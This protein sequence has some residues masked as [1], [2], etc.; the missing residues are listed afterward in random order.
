MTEQEFPTERPM[1][2]D[3]VWSNPSFIDRQI[4]TEKK[5][6]EKWSQNLEKPQRF[7]LSS[8]KIPK[9]LMLQ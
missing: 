3:L 4:G 1:I 6:Q 8:P 5:L 2:S 9:A 7:R